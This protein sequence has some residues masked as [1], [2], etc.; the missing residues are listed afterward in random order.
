MIA[1]ILAFHIA[2]SSSPSSV[3]LSYREVPGAVVSVE[4]FEWRNGEIPRRI[5]LQDDISIEQ[6]AT[7]V[8]CRPGNV[9]I[10]TFLR[11]DAAYLV[12][13]P[14]VCPPGD[15]GRR[16]GSIWQKTMRVRA[17]PEAHP[18]AEVT[19]LSATGDVPDAWP[20]CV[21]S[22]MTT[23]CWG[24]PVDARGVLTFAGVDR[25]WWTVLAGRTPADFAGSAW[26]RLVIVG[27]G[28]ATGRIV[29]SI[30]R[31]VAPRAERAASVRLD[32]AVVSDASAILVAP[33]VVWIHGGEIP[34][35]SWIEVRGERA[36]PAY[37]AL[38]E[39]AHGPPGLPLWITLD[40][41]R[42]V[43]GLALSAH[44]DIAAGTVATLFRLIEPRPAKE[45]TH[46]P[47]RTVF[48]GERVT[49]AAGAF[50]FGGLGDA[51]YEIVGWHPQF[52]RGV[53]AV[54]HGGGSVSVR[55]VSV[56]ETR[57]RVVADG[58]PL[59]GVDVISLPDPEAYARAAD[60]TEVKG[61]DSRTG[62]DGRFVVSLAPG[63]GGEVRVGGGNYPIRRFPLP[64]APL[65]TVDLGDI[66]LGPPIAV[67]VVLDRDPGCD[68]RAVGPVGSVGLQVIVATRT[69][70][71]LF[72]VVFPEEGTWEV[73]LACGRDGRDEQM[74]VPS[75]VSVSRSIVGKELR[76]LV[77]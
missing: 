23:E 49:D 68:V 39:V 42:E 34:A 72:S 6:G 54:P 13:G 3:V 40:E 18:P 21:W 52:G 16:L 77:R 60:L 26:G 58:K 2:S 32:T 38:D 10:V 19:W 61:G 22:G 4:L 56:G 65:S 74:L 5:R 75:V 27:N 8:S 55:L 59:A 71:G 28:S 30:A 11:R 29:A 64:R 25:T 12:D 50:Q 70:P 44:G 73:L 76:F 41:A 53:A 43:N 15:S 9:L 57:G 48:A 63:G 37:L 24:V 46:P 31:V 17:P 36:G 20:R 14:F 1:A 35:A 45:G 33:N 47:P 66:D 69:G 51:E 62:P 7:S 67:T